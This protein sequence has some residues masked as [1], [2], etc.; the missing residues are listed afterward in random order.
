M[1]KLQSAGFL[2]FIETASVMNSDVKYG[3]LIGTIILVVSG[4]M[5]I[6]GSD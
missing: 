6:L 1:N 3:I 4:V 2:F 5:V